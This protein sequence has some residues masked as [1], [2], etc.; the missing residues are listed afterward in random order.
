MNTLHHAYWTFF[1]SRKQ[2]FTRWFVLG[3]ILPDIVYYVMF[4]Y[5]CVERN[6]L[7]VIDDPDPLRSL[8]QLV[9]DLFEHPVVFVLRQVGHSLF[10]WIVV[11]VIILFWQG[12]RLTKWT[13]LMYG[14]LGH[15]ILDL[16]TH[17]EDAV[18]VFYPVSSYVFR[19]KIS[20]WDD[21]YH[22]EIFSLINMILIVA[23]V[24]YMLYEKRKRKRKFTKSS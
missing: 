17:V 11:F 1:A 13:A 18:P 7:Q 10:V 2:R 22:A 8:F 20:Y 14:W 5:L 23:S 15:V 3:G 16:L 4:L 19:S 9:L 6:A 12:P 21:E 24:L